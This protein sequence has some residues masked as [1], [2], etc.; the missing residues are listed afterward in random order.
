MDVSTGVTHLIVL[1]YMYLIVAWSSILFWWS[2]SL[3]CHHSA[4]SGCSP[5]SV[6]EV[7]F[8]VTKEMHIY[9]ISFIAEVHGIPPFYLNDVYFSPSSLAYQIKR[10]KDADEVP[11]VCKY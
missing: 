8:Y 2:S 11:M 9:F 3:L 1:V 5:C 4:M 7:E 6:H 10:V